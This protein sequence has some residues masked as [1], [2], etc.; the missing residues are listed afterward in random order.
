[1]RAV[2]RE[3][4]KGPVPAVCADPASRP[5]GV[6]RG[7]PKTHTQ[8][9]NASGLLETSAP[10]LPT[11]PNGCGATDP[12]SPAGRNAGPAG[13]TT[14]VTTLGAIT[15]SSGPGTSAVALAFILRF[16]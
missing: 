14:Y 12:A 6:S 9:G 15:G 8:H 16:R 10:A 13:G 3:R 4:A 7:D 2:V 11:P 5:G 1:M